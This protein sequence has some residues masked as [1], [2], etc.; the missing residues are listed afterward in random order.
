MNNLDEHNDL[1][2]REIFALCRL[3]AEQRSQKIDLR[4]GEQLAWSGTVQEFLLGNNYDDRCLKA[5]EQLLCRP[6][7][8]VCID[9]ITITLGAEVKP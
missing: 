2:A 8:D 6:W 3:T 5:V 7:S 9:G 1:L 4:T